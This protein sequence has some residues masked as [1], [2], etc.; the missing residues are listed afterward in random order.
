M[1]WTIH[2]I[3][4][5]LHSLF[6][7]PPPYSEESRALG[8]VVLLDAEIIHDFFMKTL[9]KA[10]NIIQVGGYFSYAQVCIL[11]IIIVIELSKH[12]LCN[13]RKRTISIPAI[14]LIL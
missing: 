11:I 9:V 5:I 10:L 12:Q 2:V 7:P 3:G 6:Y 4:C 1:L 14:K 13:Y 8:F